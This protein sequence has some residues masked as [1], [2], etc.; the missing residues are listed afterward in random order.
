MH[1]RRS[2]LG[3]AFVAALLFNA[4]GCGTSGPKLHKMTGKVTLDGQPVAG[5][6]V[7]FEPVVDDPT[8][9]TSAQPANGV[10][11]SDGIYSLTTNTTND[12]VA[13]GV[14]KVTVTKGV[15]VSSVGEAPPPGANMAD[16]YQKMR[17]SKMTPEDQKKSA[18]KKE[19]QE[20]PAEYGDPQRTPWKVT[21]PTS[22]GTFDIPLKK[23]GGT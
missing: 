11:G 4:P 20:L 7:H 12:G 17:G 22:S 8:V 18:P 13:A 14:F 21:V 5:A 16:V 3:A 1:G 15:G 2:L 10:T 23:G 19:V 9:T 6:A